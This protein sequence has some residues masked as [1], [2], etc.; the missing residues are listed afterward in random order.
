MLFKKGPLFY[1]FY[2][3]RLFAYL[4]FVKKP[5]LLISIDLDTLFANYLVGRIRRIPLIYDSHEFFTEVPELLGRKGVKRFWEK[6]EGWIVPKLNYTITVSDSISEAYHVKYGV[7]FLTI[8]NVSY[9]RM[10]ELNPEIQKQYIA[11]YRVM[12]QGA[13]NVGRGI[14]LMIRAM[15]NLEEVLLLIVGEGDIEEELKNLTNEMNLNHRVLFVGKVPPNELHQLTVQCD[16]GLTLEEDLG[17][18]YRMSLPNKLFDYIQARI[19]VLCSDLPEMSVIVE[20]YSIGELVRSRDS[21]ALAEQIMHMLK[22]N[23]LN[24]KWKYNLEMAASELCW[25]KEEEKLK[26]IVNLAIAL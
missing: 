1:A 17:L 12:Y 15:A 18:S 19:P 16:L 22:S 11:R 3:F 5:D 10:P 7:D 4:L 21:V 26:K 8:R 6:L 9:S 13:L 25:E 14:E 24:N 23:N 2:N 20:K